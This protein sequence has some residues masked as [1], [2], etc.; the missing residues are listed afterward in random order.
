[1]NIETK[2]ST[3]PAKESNRFSI[4][5]LLEVRRDTRIPVPCFKSKTGSKDSLRTVELEGIEYYQQTVGTSDS[6]KIVVTVP[7][8]ELQE[9]IINA[10]P[11]DSTI[12]VRLEATSGYE[13]NVWT[14]E[15]TVY[16]PSE[17]FII[18]GIFGIAERAQTNCR[19]KPRTTFYGLCYALTNGGF[20][21]STVSSY[22][23][24]TAEERATREKAERDAELEK[25]RTIALKTKGI[26]DKQ[27]T[28]LKAMTLD[29][30]SANATGL[31]LSDKWAGLYETASE[32]V[33]TYL[34]IP[35]KSD[36]M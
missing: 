5:S 19:A 18:L 13:G 8:Q 28:W 31:M 23:A 35:E 24:E 32:Q 15:T 25:F 2:K 30:V 6:I 22:I 7:V 12:P 4:K 26:S 17:T 29:T 33:W 16:M 11:L 10:N 9:L 36:L 14:E 34:E 3:T 20:N 27:K 21:L 1:M